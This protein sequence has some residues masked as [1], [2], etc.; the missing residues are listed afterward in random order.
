[1]ASSHRKP[2]DSGKSTERRE[3]AP[4]LSKSA[5]TCV[6][7]S[8]EDL[9][10]GVPP[11]M[12]R[13]LSRSC[14]IGSQL[15]AAASSTIHE[16]SINDLTLEAGNSHGEYL[17]MSRLSI[18]KDDSSVAVPATTP[19]VKCVGNE[20]SP[21]IAFS[22][23]DAAANYVSPSSARFSGS[24]THPATVPPPPVNARDDDDGYLHFRSIP[25]TSSSDDQNSG[26]SL[27]RLGPPPAIPTSATDYIM[28]LLPP[29][30]HT[31][32]GLRA[33]SLLL[34]S[35]PSIVDRRRGSADSRGVVSGSAVPL[36]ENRDLSSVGS[37]TVS[38]GFSARHATERRASR[39]PNLTVDAVASANVVYTGELCYLSVGK[40]QLN[41]R[42]QST[43]AFIVAVK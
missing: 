40:S 16:E 30:Q 26:G 5:T 14:S 23:S 41:D 8:V 19:S 12:Y 13:C 27:E 11:V 25:A 35:K 32:S 20:K 3:S 10:D 1:M 4:L 37:S 29:K 21:L 9:T 15:S 34:S 2:A 38:A 39:K 42:K 24:I 6:E 22:H 43:E 33:Q 28:P 31:S 17:P 7:S 36:R 18:P